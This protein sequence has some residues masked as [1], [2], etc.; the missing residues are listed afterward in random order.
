MCDRKTVV[1]PILK[2]A[3]GIRDERMPRGS[4]QPLVDIVPDYP[5]P[6]ARASISR[7]LRAEVAFMWPGLDVAVD[8]RDDSTISDVLQQ[9]VGQLDDWFGD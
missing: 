4:Q 7:R 5:F 9:L 6:S 1:A 3:L 2:R 8:L